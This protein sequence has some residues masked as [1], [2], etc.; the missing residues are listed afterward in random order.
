MNCVIYSARAERQLARASHIAEAVMI[1]CLRTVVLPPRGGS[2]EGDVAGRPG[3]Y[4]RRAV[5]RTDAGAMARGA[6]AQEDDPR[7]HWNWVIVYRRAT[8][9][10][11]ERHG[12]GD[13]AIVV[14]GVYFTGEVNFDL[15]WR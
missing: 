3:W 9:E 7:S 12:C 5:S 13:D 2:D 11:A 14:E 8:P 1:V 6:W 4:F 15:P 10:E